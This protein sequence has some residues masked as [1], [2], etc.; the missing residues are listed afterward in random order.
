MLNDLNY[1]ELLEVSGGSDAYKA[2]ERDGERFGKVVIGARNLVIAYEV[3][4]IKKGA[5]IGA[6]I[7]KNSVKG[8]ILSALNPIF[9]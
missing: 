9:L 2:G 5:E 7:V 6:G 1:N 8:A 3:A 4:N